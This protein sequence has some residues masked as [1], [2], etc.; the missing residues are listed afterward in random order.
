MRL[1]DVFL[2]V[3]N[4]FPYLAGISSSVSKLFNQVIARA[5]SLVGRFQASI[6]MVSVC[7]ADIM[8]CRSPG[9]SSTIKR[10]LK[11]EGYIET[12]FWAFP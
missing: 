2:H 9:T 11:G 8:Q 4:V 3:H 7:S 12:Y 6:S 10:K 1:A 5:G